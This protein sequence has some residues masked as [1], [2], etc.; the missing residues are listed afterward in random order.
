[1]GRGRE[2]SLEKINDLSPLAGV[3]GGLDVVL[4]V[5]LSVSS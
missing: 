4:L 2:R 1:M 3:V 5:F